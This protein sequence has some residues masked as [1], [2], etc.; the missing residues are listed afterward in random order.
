LAIADGLSLAMFEALRGLRDA[1]TFEG[2]T[3]LDDSVVV[4]AA[5]KKQRTGS[6][7]SSNDIQ[8]QDS[9]LVQQLVD[10]VFE[11]SNA[12]DQM[13]DNNFVSTDA[14]KTLTT[15]IP[16]LFKHRTRDEQM[17]YIQELIDKN[18][19]IT[20]ELYTAVQETIQQRNRC[21]QYILSSNT[22]NLLLLNDTETSV[23]SEDEDKETNAVD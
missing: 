15:Q 16:S 17:K 13:L 3:D 22:T 21:R 7:T 4:A 20:Q 12:I 18:N 2:E 10:A 9:V 19:I 14:S 23:A 1:A 5:A 8:Q 6:S 11:K